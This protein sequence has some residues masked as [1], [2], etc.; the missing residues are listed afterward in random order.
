MLLTIWFFINKSQGQTMNYK[1]R[2]T[3]IWTAFDL[4]LNQ[5]SNKIIQ[6]GAVKFNIETEEVYA[7]LNVLVQIDEPL[8]RD[9]AIVDIVALTGIT[10]ERLEKDGVSLVKAYKA[11]KKFHQAEVTINGVEHAGMINPIVWGGGDSRTLKTQIEAAKGPWQHPDFYC[12]GNREIDIK[13]FHQI[14]QIANDRPFAGGLAKSFHKW[15]G[16]FKGRAHDAEVD[17]YNTAM[18]ACKLYKELK[19]K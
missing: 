11:L 16:Q 19:E 9:P 14:M 6:I 3:K 12:F 1:Q 5:P 10:E 17:A 7:A 2:N 4:E 8:Q 15:G 13:S 18:F